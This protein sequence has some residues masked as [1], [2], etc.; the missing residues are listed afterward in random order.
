MRIVDLVHRWTGGLIGLLLAMLG[1]TGTLLIHKDAW[2]RPLLPHAADPQ[3]Q[4][5]ATL[6]ATAAR[7]FDGGAEQPSSILFATDGFGLNRLAYGGETG[8][9]ASQAGQI[10][11]RWDSVWERPELWLFDL[12]H[13]LL[14]GETGDIVAGIAGL[15]G[16]GFVVTGAILWWRLRKTFDFRL[17]PRR[18]SRA[19]VL[20]HHRDLGIVVAPLLLLTMLTG[21]MMTL[22]PV[23]NLL[24]SP[25]SP[26]AEMRGALAPPKVKG[27]T[28]GEID[29][30]RIIDT[31]RARY[32]DA[33]IRRIGI[34]TKPGDLI[35]V[36]ARQQA[37]WLP[38]GRTLFWFD[39]AD[40]RLIEQRDALAM[41][42]GTRFFN[43]AYP[44]H[45]A[46]VGGLAYRLV[47]TA[48]GLG[49]TLLGSLAMVTFWSSR[50]LP[51][52]KARLQ[53]A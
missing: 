18:M 24:L 36:R 44:V 16:I 20:R 33:E 11:T 3:A 53:P 42:L 22:Q 15:I 35:S 37:E 52:R 14:M 6:A 38:N 49:L 25:F 4:D 2:L 10:V 32:P 28:P 12:H 39:P 34:P 41:P 43:L 27:G 23:A 29:W 13:H 26:P 5:A 48:S 31:V 46:K 1:L 45:A 19:S 50:R 7:W 51:R 21:T 9:Y 17:W 40:G 8:A 47:M 30:R